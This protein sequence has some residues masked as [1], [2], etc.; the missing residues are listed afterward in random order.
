MLTRDPVLPA[1]D[2]DLKE[3]LLG[4]AREETKRKLRFEIE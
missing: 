4:L 2:T 3:T 1:D